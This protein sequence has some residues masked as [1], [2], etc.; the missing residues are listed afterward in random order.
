MA[1]PTTPSARL[2][3][4]SRTLASAGLNPSPPVVDIPRARILA[5]LVRPHL[6]RYTFTFA[7]LRDELEALSPGSNRLGWDVLDHLGDGWEELGWNALHE[8]VCR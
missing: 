8:E 5:D 3:Y 4:P 1:C 2:D 6:D 7:W